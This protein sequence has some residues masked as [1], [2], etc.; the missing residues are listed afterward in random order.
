MDD[1]ISITVCPLALSPLAFY[2]IT[3]DPQY[4]WMFVYAASIT[5]ITELIKR[6]I[7]RYSE[8]PVLKRPHGA[9]NCGAFNNG[10]NSEYMP[11]FPSGH[12]ALATF[13]AC[14]YG[15]DKNIFLQMLGIG[16]IGCVSY[17][18]MKKRCHNLLQV[19]GGACLGLIAYILFDAQV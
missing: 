13:L 19:L 4:M 6:N 16:Y 3:Q 17:A 9:Y 12:V 15:R 10:G 11:G 1:I 14:A 7:V 18:R 5:W 8:N 2:Y